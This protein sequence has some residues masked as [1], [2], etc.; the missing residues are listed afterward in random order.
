[1]SL[2]FCSWTA[3]SI[4]APWGWEHVLGLTE[5]GSLYADDSLGMMVSSLS[6]GLLLCK[7]GIVTH[8]PWNFWEKGHMPVIFLTVADG[9]P[10]GKDENW[11]SS[12]HRGKQSVDRHHSRKT[13]GSARRD[14]GTPPPP[15]PPHRGY[16]RN[17][18]H[19]RRGVEWEGLVG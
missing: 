9:F 15:A 19:P 7:M 18:S 1:M 4:P 11:E 10:Q 6:L 14:S 16:W 5:G 3:S 8:T 12:W 17:V 2:T 13:V